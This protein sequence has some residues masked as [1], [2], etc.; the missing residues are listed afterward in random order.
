[1]NT[2]RAV[3]S[4]LRPIRMMARATHSR[5]L[6]TAV[7]AQEA[8]YRLRRGP[9]PSP[10]WLIRPDR[11][12]LAWFAKQA[13]FG[14][15]LSPLVVQHLTGLT[16]VHVRPDFEGKLIGVGS[17][18]SYVRSGDVVLG[19][20]LIREEPISLP[21]RASVLALRGPLSA[22]LTG[23]DPASVEYGDP[24]LLAAAALGIERVPGASEIGVI[25]HLVDHD[26][27]KN[28]LGRSPN[29]R[30][31]RLIDVQRSPRE[32]LTDIAQTRV[33]VSTS[34][35][36]LI[37]AESLGIPAVWCRVSDAITGGNFKFRDYFAGTGRPSHIPPLPLPEALE[38]ADTLT[39]PVEQP[40]VSGIAR[41]F[42]RLNLLART[43]TSPLD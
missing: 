40:D 2:Y 8:T 42:A 10:P 37:C 31:Y 18:L 22:E 26:H 4:R 34:L 25:P 33:C 5:V 12:A 14:D 32:V 27:I 23:L 35:H 6:E 20:G 1:M 43:E 17:V 9:S 28:E 39:A 13:N 11:V 41:A 19:A 30:E 3:R 38:L 15:W 7:S 29:A 21:Q 36:G 16:P 24:G